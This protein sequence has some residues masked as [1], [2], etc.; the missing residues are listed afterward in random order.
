MSGG[1][2]SSFPCAAGCWAAERLLPLKKLSI[3]GAGLLYKYLS[4]PPPLQHDSEESLG[5]GLLVLYY[6]NTS[7]RRWVKLI[8]QTAFNLHSLS[9]RAVWWRQDGNGSG[10]FIVSYHRHVSKTL[11]GMRLGTTTLSSSFSWWKWATWWSQRTMV[12]S[13]HRQLL[14][15]YRLARDRNEPYKQVLRVLYS[16]S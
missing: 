10:E 13:N 2:I 15:S 16:F 4:C 1:L 3:I 7:N 5:W 14:F 9:F 6:H 12:P 8:R 11:N